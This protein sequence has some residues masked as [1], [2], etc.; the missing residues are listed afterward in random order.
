M[1]STNKT[2]LGLSQFLPNDKP[3]FLDDYNSDMSIINN[4]IS[5]NN[6][7]ISELK[8]DLTALD[9]K[10]GSLSN[11]GRHVGTFDNYATPQAA[12]K[13]VLPA[14]ISGL[15]ISA[16]E[17]D[18]AN[19]RVDE[20]QGNAPTRYIIASIN[21]S[22][23]G[24]TWTFDMDYDTDVSG[25]MDLQ[26]T[27]AAGNLAVFDA[28]GQ[29]VD[30]GFNRCE[31][32]I[33]LPKGTN[34]ATIIKPGFYRIEDDAV[35]GDYTGLPTNVVSAIIEVT[36]ARVSSSFHYI[37]KVY[38]NNSWVPSHARMNN[39]S[40]TNAPNYTA[41]TATWQS[42]PS[43]A[44][45]SS[46]TRIDFEKQ[47]IHD[48]A[49]GTY[50]WNIRHGAGSEGQFTLGSLQCISQI[51]RLLGET[52]FIVRMLMPTAVNTNFLLTLPKIY[53]PQTYFGAPTQYTIGGTLSVA[54]TI[55]C[56]SLGVFPV[57]MII[58]QKSDWSGITIG[59][60]ND[61]GNTQEGAVINYAAEMSFTELPIPLINMV[62]ASQSMAQ[63]PSFQID[64]NAVVPTL[65]MT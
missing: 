18:F 36:R 28:N 50:F 43:W 58:A 27:A 49:N 21:S 29:V 1:A 42:A 48:T 2:S 34:I 12:G 24:I 38:T 14:N 44:T 32:F 51:S 46:I 3:T 23:G 5:A 39:V 63:L 25:K 8:G 57:K 41:F 10:V 54:G 17:N 33:I 20:T 35:A 7:D 31:Q 37:Q 56:G 61:W 30:S 16:T 11:L 40:L 4:N 13:T 22:T 47:I 59:Q 6:T 19:V 64:I 45:S 62:M 9:G 65:I 53:L 52:S 60:G 55:S 15:H 26:E